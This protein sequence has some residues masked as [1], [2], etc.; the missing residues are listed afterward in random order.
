MSAKN[1]LHNIQPDTWLAS[2]IGALYFLVAG[3]WLILREI[4][5]VWVAPYWMPISDDWLLLLTLVAPAI[6]FAAGWALGFPRWSYP[7]TGW[8]FVFSLYLMNASI[9]FWYSLG[10]EKQRW[11][12]R[13]WIPALLAAATG[14]ILSW[15]SRSRSATPLP[16]L[17]ERVGVNAFFSNLRRDWSLA[18]YAMFAWMP[19][20]ITFA[21]D[22]MDRLYSLVYLLVLSALMVATALLYQR[23]RQEKSRSVILASG[24]LAI[25]TLTEIGMIAYYLPTGG[26]DVLPAVAQGVV[27][28]AIMLYPLWL[29]RMLKPGQ[30]VGT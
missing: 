4:P 2:L 13:A 18:T 26:V 25:L 16:F 5:L 27:V 30:A 10:L 24:V 23:A 21:F 1:N 20:V 9:P 17:G 11:G 22:E 14:A 8:L 15:I 12:W 7:Y 28:A 19:L 29:I 6:G 3:V